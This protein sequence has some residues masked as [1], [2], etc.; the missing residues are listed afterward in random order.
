MSTSVAASAFGWGPG[1][2]IARQ[3]GEQFGR[4]PRRKPA[5]SPKPPPLL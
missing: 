5:L 2:R 3:Y 1:A 4:A